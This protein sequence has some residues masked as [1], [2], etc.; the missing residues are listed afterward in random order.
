MELRKLFFPFTD[1]FLGL[2]SEKHKYRCNVKTLNALQAK[3][4][5]GK[6]GAQSEGSKEAV[7]YMMR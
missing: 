1:N 6:G 2:H 5:Q 7:D 4:L 3:A